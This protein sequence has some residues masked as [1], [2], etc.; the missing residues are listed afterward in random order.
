ME[1]SSGLSDA[2]AGMSNTNHR[3][4]KLPSPGRW[5]GLSVAKEYS[6]EAVNSL[7]CLLTWLGKTWRHFSF[8]FCVS[9]CQES[10]VFLLNTRV[11]T[12][13]SKRPRRWDP[14]RGLTTSPH[15]QLWRTRQGC[16]G[17]RTKATE[18]SRASPGHSRRWSLPPSISW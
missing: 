18:A 8:S 7:S 14:E 2:W 5:F 3:Q 11:P 10:L 9:P 16:W 4:R 12:Q 17:P 13:I 6:P 15:C 1:I